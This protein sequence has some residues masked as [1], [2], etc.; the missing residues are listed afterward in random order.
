MT[1]FLGDFPASAQAVLVSSRVS[2]RAALDDCMQVAIIS[3]DAELEEP[4]ARAVS[5]PAAED[6]VGTDVAAAAKGV[7]SDCELVMHSRTKDAVLTTA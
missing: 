4:N 2:L 5:S 1:H 3:P 7:L 6:D